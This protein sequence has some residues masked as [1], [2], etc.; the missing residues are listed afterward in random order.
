MLAYLPLAG[1]VDIEEERG[2]LGK[3][4]AGLSARMDA[5]ENRLNG[6][7]AER[8]PQEIVQKERD[9]LEAVRLEAEQ[10]QEQLDRLG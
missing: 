9:N 2:R 3:V 8:A 1:L 6:P 7:F 4:L 5:S 10:V